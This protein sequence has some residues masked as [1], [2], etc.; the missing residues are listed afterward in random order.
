MRRRSILAGGA[1]ALALAS[2][3]AG[4]ARAL[5]SGSGTGFAAPL[6]RRWAEAARTA[7][8]VQVDYQVTGSAGGIDQVRNGVVDFGAT[9][10][11]MPSTAREAANLLQF[12]TA[13]GSVVPVINLPGI[14]SGQLRLTGELLAEIYLGTI[15]RWNDARI[16]A[17]N[18]GL[19][20]P[21]LAVAPVH[22]SD[23][24]GTTSVF[25]SFLSAVSPAWRESAG[26]PTVVPWRVGTGATGNQG[27]AEA[28]A[29]TQGAVGYVEMAY[30]TVRR[31]VT[32]QLRNR[33]GHFVSP[34]MESFEA[35]AANAD[36]NVPGFA[37]NVINQPGAASWPILAPTFILLP[38]TPTDAARSAHVRRFF[39]WAFREGDAIARNLL[40][41]PLPQATR[42]AIRGAWRSRFGA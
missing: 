14:G 37:A 16:V 18:P 28:V 19:R 34:S 42:E 30:A 39:D 15:T 20:M 23:V 25:A 10:A 17:A 33:D 9:D 29:I 21:D 13:M 35:A 12:P 2:G 7:I 26:A 8:G 22:R 24:S 11:P 4:T 6:Y 41:V 40:Y 27:I 1:A 5:I 3:C 32:T 38:L 31:L 36:W